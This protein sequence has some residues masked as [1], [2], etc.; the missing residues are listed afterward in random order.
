M[1]FDEAARKIGVRLD[2]MTEESVMIAFRRAARLA[3]PD[4]GGGK[5]TPMSELVAAKDTL[6]RLVADPKAEDETKCPTCNG[7]GTVPSTSMFG[8]KC[9]SCNGSGRNAN[10]SGRR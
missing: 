7:R 8:A 3:H 10:L 2:G 4:V 5:G 6:L 9:K 1:T